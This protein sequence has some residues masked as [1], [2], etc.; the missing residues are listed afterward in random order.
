TRFRS[1]WRCRY[2]N[3]KRLMRARERARYR[4][5]APPPSTGLAVEHEQ[6]LARE[7]D[8]DRLAARGRRR[9]RIVEGVER[10]RVLCEADADAHHGA[11]EAHFLD[12]AVHP[13]ALAAHAIEGHRL[14]AQ[15]HGAQLARFYIADAARADDLLAVDGDA[16]VRGVDD[17][18]A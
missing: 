1:W 9:A 3:H 6:V 13:V 7:A 11:E 2:P 14:R 18:A 15:R 4:R 17:A 12:R 10:D 16:T 5:R 8:G